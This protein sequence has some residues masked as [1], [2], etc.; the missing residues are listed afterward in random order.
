[1]GRRGRLR[2]EVR[3]KLERVESICD[4]RGMM[5][6][7]VLPVEGA[8]V[9]CVSFA[10]AQQTGITPQ[11]TQFYSTVNS[12]ITTLRFADKVLEAFRGLGTV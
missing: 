4:T 3:R 9:T 7:F 6:F 8:F 12:S 11:H 1:M 10:P 2:S 5:R